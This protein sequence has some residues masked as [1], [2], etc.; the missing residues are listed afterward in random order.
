MLAL[1]GCVWS[2]LDVGSNEVLP[3]GTES[4]G[5]Y[6]DL[7]WWFVRIKV[8]EVGP[9]SVYLEAESGDYSST[10]I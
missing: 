1:Y 5:L 6:S 8:S 7:F 10:H 2:V 4:F 3:P 9:E